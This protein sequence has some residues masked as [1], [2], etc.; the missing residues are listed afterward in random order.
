MRVGFQQPATCGTDDS[1]GERRA[2]RNTREPALHHRRGRYGEKQ[3]CGSPDC[4]GCETGKRGRHRHAGHFHRREP[5][6]KGGAVLRY[7]T[8]R[9]AAIQERKYSA[10][11]LRARHDA[12]V[13]QGILPDG[14]EPQGAAEVH[15]AQH[16]QVPLPVRGHPSGG[17]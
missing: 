8:E 15:R 11:P 2:A 13:V 16:G 14:D 4:R 12:G 3:L 7:R 1:I 9:G 6:R 5:E 17:D 10:A